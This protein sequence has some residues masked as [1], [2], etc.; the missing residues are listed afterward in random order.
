MKCWLLTFSP[1]GRN[2]ERKGSNSEKPIPGS[3]QRGFG[4]GKTDTLEVITLVGP[5]RIMISLYP[6]K[7]TLES[8]IQSKNHTAW[9]QK[10]FALIVKRSGK[11]QIRSL[12]TQ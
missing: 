9:L 4:C 2:S 1:E 6:E 10:V 7:V 8:F 5:Y 3:I 11:S 12:K